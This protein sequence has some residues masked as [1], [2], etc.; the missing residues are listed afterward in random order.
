MTAPA[1]IAGIDVD[2]LAAMIAEAALHSIV[3][4]SDWREAL[5]ERDQMLKALRADTLAVEP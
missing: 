4:N 1:T 2:E 5:G 3:D